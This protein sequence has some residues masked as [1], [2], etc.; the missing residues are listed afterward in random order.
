MRI[1]PGIT[2]TLS[3]YNAVTME[4]QPLQISCVCVCV[5]VCVF[6]SAIWYLGLRTLQSF[7]LEPCPT[8]P[9]PFFL[10]HVIFWFAI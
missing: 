9:L 4:C 7:L 3:D 8:I 6:T 10:I 1:G 2:I 5:C